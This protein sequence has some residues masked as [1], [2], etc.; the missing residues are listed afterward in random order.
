MAL[1]IHR[2]SGIQWHA[3]VSRRGWY[4]YYGANATENITLL[5]TLAARASTGGLGRSVVV[6]KC[7][8]GSVARSKMTEG[9][10]R[11]LK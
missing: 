1:R 4:I 11:D 6:G 2:F 7:K 9:Q 8:L 3:A 5:R 10:L